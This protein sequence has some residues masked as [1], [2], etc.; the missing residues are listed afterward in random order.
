MRDQLERF[1]EKQV[2]FAELVREAGLYLLARD[3]A[4]TER[5]EEGTSFTD[6]QENLKHDSAKQTQVIKQNLRLN[7]FS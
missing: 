7:L 6:T 2:G 1:T 3:Q 5:G 4:L